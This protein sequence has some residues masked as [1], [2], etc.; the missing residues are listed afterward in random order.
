MSEQTRGEQIFHT[1]AIVHVADETGADRVGTACLI[2]AT[3]RAIYNTPG[4]DKLILVT[5][6]HVVTES[7]HVLVSLPAWNDS[8][9]K[10]YTIDVE[11]PGTTDEAWV[12][13]PDLDLAA[14]PLSRVLHVKSGHDMSVLGI[15]AND[16]L[17]PWVES[18]LDALSD[19]F[20]VGFPDGRSNPISSLPLARRASPS[21]PFVGRYSALAETLLIDGSVFAGSSGSAVYAKQTGFT[22]G[23]A[24]D[25][26]ALSSQFWFVG[27][28]TDTHYVSRDASFGDLI[29]KIDIE[30][31]LG[32]VVRHGAVFRLAEKAARA[33]GWRLYHNPVRLR[34][35]PEFTTG[36]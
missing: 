13:E 16:G 19:L 28:L 27:L 17:G 5:A 22:Q 11:L 31:D 25:G 29:S 3:D 30:I 18:D 14:F 15:A 10:P 2:S 21:T 1:V 32:L 20:F 7:T 33:C 34:D 35:Y 36:R 9:V 4:P 6:L 8:E 26:F 23:G 12:S 24:A